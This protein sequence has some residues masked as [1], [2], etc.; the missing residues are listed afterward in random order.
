MK[1]EDGGQAFPHGNPTDG[2]DIGMSLR[3]W[4]AGQAMKAMMNDMMRLVRDDGTPETQAGSIAIAP[5]RVKWVAQMAYKQADAMLSQ[6][7]AENK[8]GGV[9]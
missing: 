8:T 5:D 3:D 1:R 9:E 7:E 4:F 6:R 2:G